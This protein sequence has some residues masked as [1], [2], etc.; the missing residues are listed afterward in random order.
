MKINIKK[1]TELITP[2]LET[3]IQNKLMPLAKLVKHADETGEAEIWLEVSRT[4]NHHK[5]GDVF[6]AAADLRL[7]HKV[8]RGEAT[9]SDIHMAID[10]V[11]DHLRLEIDKYKAKFLEH[12][13]GGK[14]EK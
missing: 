6:M 11:R 10:Q 9:A 13:R 2:S 4:T 12:G 14:E 7:A 1:T 8:L 3:Y 5:K